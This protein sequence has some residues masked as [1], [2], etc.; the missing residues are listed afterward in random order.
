[1]RIKTGMELSVAPKSRLGKQKGK[2][3]NPLLRDSNRF[4]RIVKGI[5]IFFSLAVI[6]TIVHVYIVKV[7]LF[8]L[9]GPMPGYAA[10]EN[11]ENDLSSQVISAD[12]VSLGAYFRYNRSQIRYEEISPAVISTL[13][14][15]ED[16]RFYSHSGM[17]FW[18]YPR[19][20]LGV[21]TFRNAGGGSTI[22]Q[23]LAKNLYT[24]NPE[25]DGP[26]AAL[27]AWP[28]RIVQKTKEWI[29][30]IQ[31]EKNFTKEEIITMY[32]NTSNFGSNA[33]GLKVASETYF[34]KQPSAL[35]IQEAAMLVGMLQNPSL[36]HP[37]AHPEA[38]LKKRNQVLGKLLKH[39]YLAEAEYDS[40]KNLPIALKY[41]VQNQNEGLAPYFR[42][43]IQ[44]ELEQWC[45]EHRLDL[46]E[47]GLKIFTT[48]DS[49]MQQ[50]AE[51]SMANH[52]K[53][54]QRAFEE[55]WKVR[56]REPWVDAGG[57]EIEGFLDQKIK[58]TDAYRAYV[59]KYGEN[60]DSVN[61]M[62]NLKKRMTV[63][64]WNGRRDTLFSSMDSLRYY[65]RFLQSGLM[66]MDPGTGE[67][68]AW[69][70]GINH[71]YFKYDHVRQ[72]T[73]QAGSVFKPFVYGKAIEAGYSPCQEML[74][75]SPVIKLT[76][77]TT[78]QPPNAEGDYGSGEKLTLRQA[79]AR[80]KNSVSAQVIDLVK[81]ANV[82]EFAQ[83]LGITTRLDPVP[84][85]CLGTSDVSLYEMVAAYSSF[86]NLGI[87]TKPYYITRIE[88]K[89]G[90]V[91]ESFI[92]QT[93]QVM[94]E[95]TA[96]KMVY[97]LQGGVEEEGGTSEGINPFLKIDNEL[98]GKTG[99]TDNASDGWYI[100]I[101]HNLVAGVWTGG[102]E[103]GIHFPSWVFGSGAR[104]ARPVWENFMLKVYDNP[105]IGYGKGA[106]KRPI[107]GLDMTLDCSKLQSLPD[108]Q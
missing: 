76:D 21:L 55:Q 52:M 63:F 15:S 95:K 31:L 5:W 98:G 34:G 36:F 22:T 65:K 105:A 11:P 62:L 103:P 10:I 101:S 99:T 96:Y 56:N 41:R 16:H 13:V 33:Y 3:S 97:M 18:A 20:I 57:Y 53:T 17:D 46:Q 54:L 49:R 82:V 72:A 106:F 107:D 86:V 12:G 32:L 85:L 81:P 78:W 108:F 79:L 80:S 39:G 44:D 67:I 35:N 8:G 61:I 9:F 1:M 14:L 74:D 24:L 50:Y 27:G 51:E 4:G 73:R 102:D 77:G 90:N 25:L 40:I 60:S 45:K 69:V 71:R 26:V 6:A 75:I 43:A 70:G 47:S 84:S 94:D 7:D 42:T 37:R 30:S 92:P 91:I 29:I 2:P 59:K 68:K 48:I 64:T 100:G 23:Q 83:R 58:A 66:A 104:T 38:A 89:N 88:D 87:Y 93:R 28:R 19:V